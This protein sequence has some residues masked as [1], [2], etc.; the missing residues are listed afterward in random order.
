M[1]CIKALIF[2]LCFN[3]IE[4]IYIF[5]NI[6]HKHKYGDYHHIDF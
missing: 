1:F 3:E 5:G 2:N 6:I 4:T